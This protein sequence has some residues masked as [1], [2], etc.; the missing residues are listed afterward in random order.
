MAFTAEQLAKSAETRKR[1]AAERKEAGGAIAPP[2]PEVQDGEVLASE[3]DILAGLAKL[4]QGLGDKRK[5]ASSVKEIGRLL[6]GIDFGAYPDLAKDPTINGLIE[7]VNDIRAEST[8]IAPGSDIGVGLATQKKPWT[9]RDI[10]KRRDAGDPAFQLVE[11]TPRKSDPII[12]NGVKIQLFEDVT[13]MIPRVFRD[14]AEEA[15]RL[16]R[17]ADEH[18]SYL[19]KQRD[20]VSDPTVLGRFG[21]SPSQRFRGRIAGGEFTPNAGFILTPSNMEVPEGADDGGDEAEGD[22]A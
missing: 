7:R 4:A 22:A 16:N 8:D 15:R 20:N 17:V 1:L 13:V 12:W 3:D 18:K 11:Y 19:M 14:V 5:A 10:D 2:A 6:D 21:D 9:W